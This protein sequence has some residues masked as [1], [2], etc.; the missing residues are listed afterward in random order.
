MRDEDWQI[1]TCDDNGGG[2]PPP[3]RFRFLGQRLGYTQTECGYRKPWLL[4][5]EIRC[6][7]EMHSQ[8]R[9]D[10]AEDIMGDE[11]E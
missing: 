1:E 11:E 5:E 8:S 6:T 2:F 10:A 7:N 3:S 9:D 4:V